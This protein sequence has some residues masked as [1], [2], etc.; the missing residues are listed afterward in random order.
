MYIL[1]IS[2]EKLNKDLL[3]ADH[4]VL[5]NSLVC[6]SL[7]KTIDFCSWLP[8]VAYS[9]L[10]KVE[11]PW[12]FPHLLCAVGSCFGRHVVR[13]CGCSFFRHSRRGHRMTVSHHVVAGI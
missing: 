10:H 3:T 8:L 2:R 5:D 11:A 7:G 6:S 4:L 9:S 1:S 13:L 12:A